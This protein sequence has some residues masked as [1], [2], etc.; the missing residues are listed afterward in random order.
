MDVEFVLFD[1]YGTLLDVEVNEAD[2]VFWTALAE[3]LRREGVE[4]EPGSLRDVF[5]STLRDERS[6]VPDGFVMQTVLRRVLAA[7]GWEPSDEALRAFGAAFR[8][9]S[10]TSLSL[11]P[12]VE[13][14]VRTLRA[15]G[16]RMGIVSNTEAILTRADIE[17][18]RILKEMDVM[19]LSSEAGTKK[20]DP[21]IFREAV[22]RLGA[23]PAAGIFVGDDLE[24]DVRGA[25]RAG[26]RCVYLRRNGDE[27]GGVSNSPPVREARAELSSILDAMKVLGWRAPTEV[28]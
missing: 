10:T 8:R 24:E 26:L 5:F 4:A 21:A 15:S 13:P 25:Q 20:P 2:P 1:L 17:R 3:V 19:V 23:V 27:L 28:S 14:L 18:F 9:L 12:Y 7:C 6:R 16:C 11:L 22:Q